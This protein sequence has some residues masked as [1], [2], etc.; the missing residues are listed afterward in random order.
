MIQECEQEKTGVSEEQEKT[1][2]KEKVSNTSVALRSS[3]GR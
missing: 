2:S 1:R 3:P